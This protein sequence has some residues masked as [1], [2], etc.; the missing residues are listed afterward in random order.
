MYQSA[1][2]AQSR[3]DRLP[4]C[5][6]LGFPTRNTRDPHLMRCLSLDNKDFLWQTAHINRTNDGP[7][8][9]KTHTAIAVARDG[10]G[11][12]FIALNAIATAAD[13]PR[14][15]RAAP[16]RCASTVS[17]VM[18]G[19]LSWEQHVFPCIVVRHLG[20]HLSGVLPG[21]L[22]RSRGMALRLPAGGDRRVRPHKLRRC[23]RQEVACRCVRF[24]CQWED[25]H[26]T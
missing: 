6:A 22:R 2:K 18:Y 5:F 13:S 21:I 4:V 25:Q 10:I 15:N 7:N 1:A 8:S 12:T 19:R 3:T 24:L 23:H 9:N 26:G 20:L 16:R 17:G 11:D 14:R